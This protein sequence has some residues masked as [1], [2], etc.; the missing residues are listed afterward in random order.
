MGDAFVALPVSE[1]QERLSQST[2][3]IG[4]KLAQVE[5][6]LST[7]REELAQ[8]KAMLYARFGKGIN[9]ET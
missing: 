2:E 1:A 8:L 4:E 3:N 6:D 7:V 9:L 5:D